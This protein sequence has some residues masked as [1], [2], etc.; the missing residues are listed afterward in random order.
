MKNISRIQKV[1]FLFLFLFGSEITN[2]SNYYWVGGSGNWSD[3]A[4]HWATTSGGTTFYVQ[5]PQSVDN[6]Y[7]DANSFSSGG[8]TVTIN[9]TIVN[10]ND[11][12]WTGVTNAP[13]FTSSAANTLAIFGSLTL[14]PAMTLTL[15]GPVSFEAT[16]LGK[17]ITSAGHSF[18]ANVSF[19][20]IG[21]G[22][23]LQDAFTTAVNLNLN[24]GTLTTN[25]QTVNASIFNSNTSTPRTLNMGSSVF[26]IS[27]FAG[28][29]FWNV[30]SSGMTVNCGT[31]V[32][33]ATA[34]TAGWTPTFYGGGMT[35]YDLNF[36]GPISAG[37]SV[38]DNNTF[39]DINFLVDGTINSNNIINTATIGG[40][41]T[42]TGNNTFTNLIFTPGYTYTLT[43]GK[44]QTISN[45]IT[46]NGNCGA[47]IA[48][49]S[50]T[51]GSQSFISKASG[52]E[53]ISYATLKDISAGGGATFTAN[54]AI[55]L[56]NNSGWT[57]N[58]LA[59]QNL[60]WVGN[61][62]NWDNGNHWS[63][64]SGGAPSG[65]SPTPVDN[66]FFDMN[67][68][69]MA[70]Q[71][72]TIN[73]P[74]AYC[75]NMTWTGVTNSPTFTGTSSNTFAIY[76]SLTFAPAMTLSLG[77]PTNFEATALG[78]TIT[79]AGHSF[80][81]NVNFNG[82]GGGWT[83]QDAFTTTVNLNL[84]NG[85]LTTN[86]QTVNASI[87]NSN[88][89]MARTLNMGS[90]VFN[91]SWFAGPGFWNVSSS[92]MTVNCGTSVINATA[93]TAGWTPT[94][95]GGGMTYYDLNFT[96]PISA[97]GSVN[98]NNT[99]HNVSFIVDG[100][101]NSNNIINT[102]TIGGNGTITGNNTFTNLI[103]TPG[104]TYTLTN[105]RTQTISNL[106]TANGNCG[107]LI[108]I[109]SSTSGSQ[110]FISKASGNETISY[111]TLKDISAGGGATFTANSAID[112]GNNSGWTINLLASQNL[113]WVGNGGNWDNGNHWSL[114]SGGAPS[115]CSP[116]PV[117][118]V[119]FDMN[120][121]SMAS[122]TVTIN[123]PT[124][125]CNN[126]TW[127]GVTN[128]PTFSSSSGNVFAIYG[129]LAFDPAMTLTLNGPTNFE[130]TTLGKT[131][132]S[133]GHSFGA[134]VSFNGIG[135]GWTL[136][137]AFTTTVNLNLNNGTLTTNN[138][139]V[140]ASIFNSNTSTA[141]TLNMGSSIFNISWFAGPGFWN[142]A[143]SGMTVNCGTS[144]I[145]A[146]ANTAG[147][148][149]TFYGGGMTYYDLNF[150]GPISAGGSVNDNNTFHDINFIA[151]GTINGNNIIHAAT[152]SA[153]GTITG[154]NTFTDLTFTPAYTY[155]ITN[156][157][158]QSFT[159]LYSTGTGSFPIRIQS[160]SVGI[161][162]TFFQA[163][164]QICLDYIRIS[165]NAATGA[166][167]FNAGP[168]SQDF[169][170]NTGWNF[171]G[172]CTTTVT[173]VQDNAIALSNV[174]PN[175]TNSSVHF[176]FASPRSGEI[177]IQLLDY[178][179]KIVLDEMQNVSEGQSNVYVNMESLAQGIY[180]LKV[181]F[182]Q[183][184][185]FSITKVVKLKN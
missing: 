182:D 65:C 107:A 153:D 25:N 14:D 180:S 59:S 152:F 172:N 131:I 105:G 42:I 98:D 100:T 24:N 158:T 35:Y 30:S 108:A 159:N 94:F 155:T 55:D 92:G 44:T 17:T 97:G 121:F 104:Y 19:N 20:G 13:T 87:F 57:I 154:N 64:T 103:F 54:S 115:G 74:T 118:N 4:T 80:G 164:G 140:N 133:A 81:A 181:Q 96:G 170:G 78:K 119:F 91:I 28:P 145:N 130:A 123:V 10:C 120:S 60:F 73:V 148:T 52:N 113:F 75:N 39:H 183:G 56:G 101:I 40:N 16:S 171:P 58:L 79:S 125:Y 84:N 31:S 179:G 50:S 174:R 184:N 46:A 32:I 139:T 143:S 166:A 90:S 89:S 127:T 99:F 27:W 151:A 22:W 138:Q 1:I 169:G 68:F 66:V 165:D 167:I 2:A 129:S 116:T 45:L 85:T 83:L 5:V 88:S 156:G 61:G 3:F 95:Y 128:S 137:D 6:V 147:W 102:A 72:V 114:T 9:Q 124:A 126:M 134:N 136:Q 144:L 82:V 185:Y 176:D 112:L 146:T 67:S 7:F 47:L 93:N 23:T 69:S 175:P 29:G 21:G 51:S 161:P 33:N 150:T 76:G 86:N 178:T 12:I 168:N 177:H 48:I 106:I 109:K 26:N 160:S 8:Q 15:N 11:M 157:K 163:S 135:G 132:T 70:N 111:A 38:N 141:R 41:G 122:Q 142:V 34:N 117:D 173:P 62:G 18:N 110:S 71:T 63:L 162:T 36:T 43:S 149:P 53:T 37:G 77:G 49:K